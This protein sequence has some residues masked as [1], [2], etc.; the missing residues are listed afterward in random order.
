MTA[1]VDLLD[2]PKLI[3]GDSKMCVDPKVGLLA[4]GPYGINSDGGESVVIRAGAIGTHPSLF[5]L[6]DF[7]TRLRRTIAPTEPKRKRTQLW[8][9]EFPG[10]GTEGA[11]GFDIDIDPSAVEAISDAEE[12]KALSPE[13]RKERIVS[14]VSLYDQKFN[15]LAS[16]THPAP[17]IV[18][19]P[20]SKRLVD[21]CRD[22]R[23]KGTKITYERRTFDRRF[24]KR[25]YPLFDFHNVM[26]VLSFKH[27]LPSQIILPTTMSFEHDLQ[28]PSTIAWNLIVGIY[29][30]G[31]GSPWKLADLDEK[32]CYV[33][34]SFFEEIAQDHSSM[35]TSMA[36]VYVKKAESQIIRGKPFRWKEEEGSREPSLNSQQAEEILGDAVKL[37]ARQHE[38]SPT[39]VVVHKTSRFTEEEIEGFNRAAEGISAADYVNI[40]SIS[41]VRFYHQRLGYPPVR[42]TLITSGT[43]PAILYTVGFVPALDTYQG[44]TVP[45]PLTLHIARMDTNYRLIAQD[46][47]SLTKMDWNSTDFCASDPVTTSVSRKVGNIL[48]EMRARDIKEPPQ[49]YRFYM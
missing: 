14:V 2:E 49:A 30:K 9:R 25:D 4:F 28:D 21:K 45:W 3:L 41:G 17:Q 43:S 20:L 26:K 8:K 15:D 31:T 5:L 7:L 16:S 29:Y 1:S 48:A 47:M 38:S 27:N 44:S 39:R 35:R 33:G 18:L 19:V 32:T 24:P 11:L 36:H 12:Q 37:F 13:D 10:L 6:R 23:M 40:E 22:P 34:L 46:M 42:G